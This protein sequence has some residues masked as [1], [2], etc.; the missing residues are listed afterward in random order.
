MDEQELPILPPARRHGLRPH[1]LTD[2]S[3]A[4]WQA[5]LVGDA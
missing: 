2:G 4:L 5:L 3:Q 1:L